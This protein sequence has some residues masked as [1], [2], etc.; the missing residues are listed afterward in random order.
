MRQKYLELKDVNE[1]LLRQLEQAQQELDSLNM[2]KAELEEE[3]ATS[4]V[5]QEAGMENLKSNIWETALCVH[6]SL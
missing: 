4:P 3:L 6:Y 2:K 5:K 1:H